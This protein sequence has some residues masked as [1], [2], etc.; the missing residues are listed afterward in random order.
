MRIN[1][2]AKNLELTPKI[3][4]YLQKR[5]NYFD[6]FIKKVDPAA[7]ICD[8]ELEKIVGDQ[9]KGEI[10]R[11]EIN[12]EAA[13]VFYRSEEQSENIFSVI[14]LVKDQIARE[15]KRNKE[16][17][18]DLIRRGGRSIKKAFSLSTLARFRRRSKF[19]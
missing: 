9:R 7:I 19:K 2:K 18:V 13:G 1:L 12:L 4:N 11:A 5:L 14:D 10:F 8:V 16:K 6:R 3:K 15:L 17:K